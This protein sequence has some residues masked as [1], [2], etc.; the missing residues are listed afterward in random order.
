MKKIGQLFKL[1]N[2]GSLKVLAR[3]PPFFASFQNEL[4]YSASFKSGKYKQA[5]AIL[6]KIFS[7]GSCKSKF[8]M[9][10]YWKTLKDSVANKVLHVKLSN[11][12]L[13]YL[14]IEKLP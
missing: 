9:I 5:N 1:M 14:G 10:I 7:L 8:T 6:S 11:S 2:L 13:H 3:I 12:F 4:T